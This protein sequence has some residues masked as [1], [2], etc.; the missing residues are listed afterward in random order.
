MLPFIGTTVPGA[1]RAAYEV[2]VPRDGSYTLWGRCWSM[3]KCG[4]SCWVG[5]DDQAPVY[6]PEGAHGA[7]NY[8]WDDNSYRRWLWLRLPGVQLQ[9]GRRRMT[10]DIREDGF[11]I[12]QWALLP[13]DAPQP[14]ACLTP[15]A[16]V[17]PP[18]SP[19]LRVDPCSRVIRADQA[20]RVGVWLRRGRQA[21]PDGRFVLSLPDGATATSASAD[22]TML[23]AGT[24]V[25]REFRIAHVA[26]FPRGE[27]EYGVAY[28][29]SGATGDDG[30]STCFRLSR[31]F[32]WQVLAP[33]ARA[34][35]QQPQRRSIWTSWGRTNRQTYYQSYY[36]FE[37]PPPTE[38]PAIDASVRGLIGDVRWQQSDEPEQWFTPYGFLDFS[39]GLGSRYESATARIRTTVNAP[40][41]GICAMLVWSDDQARVWVNDR[42]VLDCA[43]TGPATDRI[44]V[45]F[46]PLKQGANTV[47]AAINQCTSYWQ[48]RMRIRRPDGNL[49]GVR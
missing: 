1:G 40:A 11:R 48:F 18:E 39:Q 41:D 45:A 29:P 22:V 15:N 9:A 31:P 36:H 19:W 28:R 27:H 21:M 8:I 20:T 49:S 38:W 6:F 14:Q 24:L 44:G 3:D 5:F 43:R 10:V 35:Q 7:A 16:P 12:D 2:D 42:Q 4:N 17:L 32:H 30:L 33:L 47:A 37:P 13:P 23:D 25:F 46:V 34:V 26:E